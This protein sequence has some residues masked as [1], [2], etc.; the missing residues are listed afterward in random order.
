MDAWAA[1]TTTVDDDDLLLPQHSFHRD[2]PRAPHRI[3]HG[4]NTA[5]HDPHTL[6]AEPVE[7]VRSRIYAVAA[8]AMLRVDAFVQREERRGDAR[9]PA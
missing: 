6:A 2:D 3:D 1:R 5:H 4:P 8:D 7:H 9:E